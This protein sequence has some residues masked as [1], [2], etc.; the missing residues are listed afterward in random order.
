V[1]QK[2]G[3]VPTVESG[4][5]RT[6]EVCA[7]GWS[8]KVLVSNVSGLLAAGVPAGPPI[9]QTAGPP[10]VMV[11]GAAHAGAVVDPVFVPA[12]TTWQVVGVQGMGLPPSFLIEMEMA[13]GG[14]LDEVPAL[15]AAPTTIMLALDVALPTRL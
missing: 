5:L 10:E 8:K 15:V 3:A 2:V 12:K 11:Q 7:P 1:V 9:D 14:L 13:V 6:K 4:E